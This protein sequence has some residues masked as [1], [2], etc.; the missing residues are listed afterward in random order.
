DETTTYAAFVKSAIAVGP[1]I[2]NVA[3]AGVGRSVRDAGRA[4]RDAVGTNTNLGTLLLIAPLAALPPGPRLRDGIGA[5]LDAL[6]LDDTRYVYESIRLAQAG[7]LG[8]TETADV[9]A[10][11]PPA[12]LLT[13]AMRMAADRDLVA[14]QYVTNFEDVFVRAATPIEFGL[15]LNLT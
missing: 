2:G 1:V 6:T 8:R 3:V 7:G 11:P 13:E 9:S 4:T 12:L 15:N 5:L 10:E 14:K